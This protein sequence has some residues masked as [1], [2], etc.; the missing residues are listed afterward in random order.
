[1]K[2]KVKPARWYR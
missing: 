1:M 2:M